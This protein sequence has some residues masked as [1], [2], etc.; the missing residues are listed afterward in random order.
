MLAPLLV[1]AAVIMIAVVLVQEYIRSHRLFE[2]EHYPAGHVVFRQGEEGDCAYFIRSGEVA[3]IDEATGAT[4]ARIC[5]GDY[6]G[7]MALI[8]NR[9]RN[10]TIRAESTVELAVLGKQN[11]LHA[12]KLMPASEAAIMNNFRERVM[13]REEPEGP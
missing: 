4:V 10:A 8:T 2:I 1:L 9:P 13:N 7:E 6:F 3:V 5:A 11:F 12:M